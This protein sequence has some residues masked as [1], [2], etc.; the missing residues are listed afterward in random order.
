MTKKQEI[1]KKTDAKIN[2]KKEFID[3]LEKNKE[4]LKL[5]KEKLM[6]SYADFDN[7]K[8]RVQKYYWRR[9]YTC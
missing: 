8:K 7:Y 3:D 9:Y 6:R 4:E 5:Q 1:K 2:K